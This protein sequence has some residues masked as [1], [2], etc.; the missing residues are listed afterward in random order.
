MN[1]GKIGIFSLLLCFSYS[2]DDLSL[3]YL[4]DNNL[5]NFIY[6][7]LESHNRTVYLLDK[8]YPNRSIDIDFLGFKIDGSMMYPMS[9]SIPKKI[10]LNPS[11]SKEF[12]KS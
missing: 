4:S 6:L 9:N 12:Q 10:F 3:Y 1:I 11:Y 8:Y 7:D 2:V 5:S